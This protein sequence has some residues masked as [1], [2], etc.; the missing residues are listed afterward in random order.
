MH[1]QDNDL[2]AFTENTM[3]TDEMIAF[4][5]HLD[6]CDFCLEEMLSKERQLP[7]IATPAYLKEQILNKAASAE[8]QASKAASAAS[9]RMQRFYHGLRTATGI[10]AALF[11]LFTIG[12]VDFAEVQPHLVIQREVQRTPDSRMDN[13]M[14][15]RNYL[16]DF[17]KELSNGLSDGS[18]KMTDCLNK[19]SNKLINGGK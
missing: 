1:I 10:I 16:H 12:Q 5:E 17:S 11:L 19:L 13:R 3:D 4:L 15:H 6:N 2:K 9:Y 8:I 7:D 14:E 18:R